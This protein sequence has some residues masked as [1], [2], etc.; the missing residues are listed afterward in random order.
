MTRRLR[1]ERGVTLMEVLVGATI[2]MVV[3]LALFGLADAGMRSTKNVQDRVES[4]QRGRTALEQVVQQLRAMVCVQNGTVA[5]A[6]NY[7]R[8]ITLAQR[9]RI[10]FYT[11][12]PTRA[13]I[14]SNASTFLPDLRS[15]VFDATAKTLV[16]H[17][18]SATQAPPNPVFG[19]DTQRT[20]LTN[21]TADG[22][23]PNFRY[24]M[25][26]GTPPALTEVTPAAGAQV[27]AAY[28]PRIVRVDVA[29]RVGPLR[30][31]DY[32]GTAASLTSQVALRLAR[33][34]GDDPSTRAGG[35]CR[36]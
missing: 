11:D 27:P 22:A 1:D 5:G 30:A 35:Q 21:V 4:E 12:V 9:D 28:L 26:D 34:Y 25:Y 24:W 16:E 20:L 2:G 23:T 29:F 36:A 15:L 17:R 8:P 6:P 33:D 13:E 19:P 32:S 3:L 7:M 31:S 18:Q 10:D 14:D